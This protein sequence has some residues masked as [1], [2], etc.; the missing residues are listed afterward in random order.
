VDLSPWDGCTESNRTSEIEGKYVIITNGSCSLI[1]KAQIL[2]VCIML[3]P[4]YITAEDVTFH[5]F[6]FTETKS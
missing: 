2:G 3:I 6:L 1:R 5:Q 4:L